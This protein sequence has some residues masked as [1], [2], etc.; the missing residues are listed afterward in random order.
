[1]VQPSD[2]V[3]YVLQRNLF[4]VVMVLIVGSARQCDRHCDV[5]ATARFR[6]GGLRNCR[7]IF[8]SVPDDFGIHGAGSTLR[9]G[10]FSISD[11]RFR[12]F[13]AE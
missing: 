3:C 6:L 7:D 2:I 10:V 8:V 9:C 11:F 4:F 1:M 12:T 5:A 13:S